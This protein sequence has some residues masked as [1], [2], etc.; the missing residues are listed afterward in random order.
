MRGRVN[1][2]SFFCIFSIYLFACEAPNT[3]SSTK[4]Q[5]SIG[6]LAP[7]IQL[8]RFQ[9]P[10]QIITLEELRGQYVLLDFWAS[11]CAPCRKENPYLVR[12][13]EQFSNQN[14]TIFSISL[15]HTHTAWKKAIEDDDLVWK[16]HASD[17]KGWENQAARD[18]GIESIPFNLLLDPEGKIIAKN[19]RGENLID[20]L[21]K[22][23]NQ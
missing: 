11:W 1:I 21:H 6:S 2:L 18:Y 12:A 9:V 23:L 14:F 15:D 22:V 20:T 13:F 3:S 7:T 16:Y 4:K 17:L 8:P 19:I 5:L 10:T